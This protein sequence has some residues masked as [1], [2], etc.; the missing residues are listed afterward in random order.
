MTSYLFLFGKTPEL[1]WLELR[2]LYSQARLIS[3]LVAF[4]EA[5]LDPIAVMR[6]LGG[7][8]K[9]AK[10]VGTV[11]E[12]SVKT[13][14]PLLTKEKRSNHITFGVSRYDTNEPI[15]KGLLADIKNQLELTGI[16]ARFVEARADSRLGSVIIAK[17][18]V[19]DLV[20]TR[21]KKTYLIARTIAVQLFE[22]WN[23][24][25]YGRPNADPKSGMLPPKVA[26]M[27]VNIALRQ[28]QGKPILLDP[29]CGMGTILAEALLTGWA[30][31]GSDQS[32]DVIKKVEE[33][34]RWLSRE[35]PS[36]ESSLDLYVSD[37]TH[38]SQNVKPESID[39]IVTEPYMGPAKLKS[40][41]K[42]IINAT[43]ISIPQACAFRDSINSLWINI[44]S[45]SLFFNK[46]IIRL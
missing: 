24:R 18:D 28:A 34:L 32:S 26:R 39:A 21:E 1:S 22:E 38:I 25:D 20:I 40:P 13:L 17:Q 35:Y 46:I 15:S 41:I 6:Q 16:G 30:V 10:V 9:I 43:I 42:N 27:L 8:V 2:S 33:N 14:V 7:T 3:P 23:R 36:I 31:L 37:A 29:F 11:T 5:V 44:N 12:I 19:V 45:S 4:V